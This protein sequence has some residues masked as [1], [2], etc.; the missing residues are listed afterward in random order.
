MGR[1]VNRER[2]RKSLRTGKRPAT[3]ASE[4]AAVV[5]LA[6]SGDHFPLDEAAAM[7]ALGAEALL[8]VTR[9]VVVAVLAEE[10]ALGERRLANAA[11]EARD[12]EVFLLDAQHLARA[13]LLARLAVR[14]T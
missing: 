9:A 3:G 6:E 10:A 8:V 2:K 12:V 7:G 4:A 1:G 13:L 5:R 11:F 14:F